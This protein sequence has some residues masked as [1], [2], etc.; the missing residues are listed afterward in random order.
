MR[1]RAR[2]H[3]QF[4]VAAF[5]SQLCLVT[6]QVLANYTCALRYLLTNRHGGRK[7]WTLLRLVKEFRGSFDPAP[8]AAADRPLITAR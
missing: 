4:A 3:V 5:V 2:A 8:A 6:L 7:E 1:A